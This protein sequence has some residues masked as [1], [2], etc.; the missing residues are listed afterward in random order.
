MDGEAWR[1]AVH[2]VTKS[3]TRLSDRTATKSKKETD[4]ETKKK[5][6]V[7]VAEGRGVMQG[8]RMQCYK[9]YVKAAQD[10]GNIAKEYSQHRIIATSGA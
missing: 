10:T 1:A 7:R 5:P 6:V 9:L 3:P 4:S 2:G 8:E